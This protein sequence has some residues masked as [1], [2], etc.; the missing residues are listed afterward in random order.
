MKAY[1]LRDARLLRM[2][3]AN[4]PH[5]LRSNLWKRIRRKVLWRDKFCRVCGPQ[6][7]TEVHHLSYGVAVLH[8]QDYDQLVGLCRE[9]HEWLEFD[10]LGRKMTLKEANR[11]GLFSHIVKTAKP[12][13]KQKKRKRSRKAKAK[14][15]P[16]AE[17]RT[18]VCRTCKTPKRLSEFRNQVNG[19]SCIQC[20]SQGRSQVRAQMKERRRNR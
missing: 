12:D 20:L 11:R 7:A 9:C 15:V 8:G 5:Y 13:P 17:L 14:K 1:R 4:Y 19:R 3:F 16:G 10:A 6:R 18:R 2:G